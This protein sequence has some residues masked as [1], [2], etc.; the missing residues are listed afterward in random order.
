M[1]HLRRLPTGEISIWEC[2]R[3]LMVVTKP[4]A[5]QFLVE[6]FGFMPPAAVEFIFNSGTVCEIGSVMYGMQSKRL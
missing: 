4:Q 5:L 2:D 6:Q 3:P 1:F